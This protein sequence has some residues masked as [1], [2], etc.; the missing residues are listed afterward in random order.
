MTVAVKDPEEK[1]AA[2]ESAEFDSGWDD[3]EFKKEDEEKNEQTEGE[4]GEEE[5]EE[6]KEESEEEESEDEETEGKEDS[7]GKEETEE[8]EESEGYSPDFKK[9]LKKLDD[10]REETKADFDRLSSLKEKPTAKKKADS[11][12]LESLDPEKY[13]ANLDKIRETDP[14]VADSV[15]AIVSDFTNTI[16]SQQEELNRLRLRT[17]KQ[18]AQDDISSEKNKRLGQIE[19]KHPG[20]METAKT[21]GFQEWIGDNPFAK[22]ILES[23]ENPNDIIEIFD[24]YT[25]YTPSETDE[26]EDES[27]KK[28]ESESQ[29]E[30][31]KN[32]RKEAAKTVQTK[33]KAKKAPDAKILSDEEEFDAGW[34][35]PEFN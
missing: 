28:Q 23:T 20:F 12:P 1:I 17:K 32:A 8:K 26:D 2:A 5:E 35:D 29:E 30:A 4:S 22:K 31:K 14:D 34:N 11:K 6:E 9:L 25:A 33:R 19:E 3:P 10:H 24:T 18:D 21:E 7:E 13:K 27:G 15:G 16:N